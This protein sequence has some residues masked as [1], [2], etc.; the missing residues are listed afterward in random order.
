MRSAYYEVLR[1]L[2][3]RSIQKETRLSERQVAMLR[4]SQIHDDEILT[5]Y[6]RRAKMSRELVE[7]LNLLPHTNSL[8]FVGASLSRNETDAMRALRAQ[9]AHEDEL[10]ARQTKKKFVLTGGISVLTKRR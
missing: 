5:A 4:W 8:V 9:F 7:A 6:K 3:F 2:V 10:A 1:N